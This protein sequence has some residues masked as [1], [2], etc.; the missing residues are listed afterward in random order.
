MYTQEIPPDLYIFCSWHFRGAFRE[1]FLADEIYAKLRHAA[2]HEELRNY[3]DN[4][5]KED[6]PLHK[7]VREIFKLPAFH[8]EMSYLEPVPQFVGHTLSDFL[9]FYNHTR[10]GILENQAERIAFTEDEDV[11][12]EPDSVLV[13]NE[14]INALPLAPKGDETPA[15]RGRGRPRKSVTA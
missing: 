13:D 2:S 15:K 10:N 4:P 8:P 6:Q 3:M 11:A 12:D 7:L 14:E 9:K 1:A 5:S